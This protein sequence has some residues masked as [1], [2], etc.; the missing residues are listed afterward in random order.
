MFYNQED[1]Y[2]TLENFINAINDYIYYY[3]YGSIKEK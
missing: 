1:R 3:N 2:E